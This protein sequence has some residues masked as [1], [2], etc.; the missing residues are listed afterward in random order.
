MRGTPPCTHCVRALTGNPE[1]PRV[2][3]QSTGQILID[4]E[5]DPFSGSLKASL[6]SVTLVEVTLAAGTYASTPVPNGRCITLTDNCGSPATCGA[7]VDPADVAQCRAVDVPDGWTCD[8]YVYDD[9]DD[10]CDC[11][12]GVIDPDCADATV[13]SCDSCSECGEAACEWIVEAADNTSCKAP[14]P[15]PAEWTCNTLY[16]GDGDCDCACGA[17]DIDCAAAATPVSCDYCGACTLQ[18]GQSCAD[19]VQSDLLACVP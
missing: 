3:F 1:A 7:R 12:C 13:G 16:Y 11:G 6:Q 9:A 15:A 4:A 14:P 17:R 2:F 10:V 19:V 5:R 18:P 8:P